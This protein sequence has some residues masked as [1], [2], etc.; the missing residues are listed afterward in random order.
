[1]AEID[2]DGLDEPCVTWTGGVTRTGP[3]Q[4][5]ILNYVRYF[6]HGDWCLSI[7]YGNSRVLSSK[8]GHLTLC[9]STG[10]CWRSALIFWVFCNL[11]S[12]SI[13][14]TAFR[15]VH[16]L[17]ARKKAVYSICAISQ[18]SQG[19]FIIRMRIILLLFTNRTNALKSMKGASK[20][21]HMRHQ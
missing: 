5:I 9:C 1:M 11:H 20:F 12:C 18:P 19:R 3:R 16:Q 21:N 8:T 17:T 10:G 13:R 7:R 14:A 2:C 4:Y 15:H 6:E